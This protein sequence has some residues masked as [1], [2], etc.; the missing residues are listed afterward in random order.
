[1][2]RTSGTRDQR[3]IATTKHRRRG[4][5]I[6]EMAIIGPVFIFVLFGLIVGGLG[7]FRYQQ[8][9]ALAYESARW[10]AVHGP[11]YS[12]V[13]GLPMADGEALMVNVIR[14]RAS[15]LDMSKLTCEIEWSSNST[16]ATV[17]LRY[18]WTPEALWAPVVFT[19]EATTFVTY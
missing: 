19:G 12:R 16:T 14:P 17:K 10:A 8:V 9:T 5:S 13:T 4:A 11:N 15:G 7:V 2:K 3:L 18:Q 6:V 1:M